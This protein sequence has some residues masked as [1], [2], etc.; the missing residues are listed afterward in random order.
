MAADVRDFG[1]G[2][3]G[4]G[5]RAIRLSSAELS[6]TVLTW[7]GALQDL[8][9]A[10]I[11]RSLT[12]GGTRMEAYEGPMGYFGTLVGPVANR[13]GG[14]R[15]LIDGR[16]CRFPA[17]E[18]P[19]LLHGGATGI[20]ARHWALDGADADSVRLRLVAEDGDD[21]FPGRR[22]ITAVYRV[23]GAALTLELTGTTDAP[24]LMNLAHHGYWNLDG[25][26][27]IAGHRLRVPADHY[28]PTD[29]A[30]LPTGEIRPVSGT[31]DLRAGRV[32]D[33]GEGFDTNFCIAAAAGPLAE[34]AELVGRSGVAMR[35]DSTEP[36]LQVY[37]GRFLNTA[38]FA[39]HTGRPYGAHEGLALE[40]Q[41]WPDAPNHP[42]FP[43]IGLAPGETYRQVTRWS[44]SAP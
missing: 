11:D 28:L 19:N 2:R 42:A 26:P 13:I 44:F 6:A 36:G 21:G 15:A 30:L 40:P 20:Q 31:H 23:E 25:T 43:P 37:D 9:L 38:P 14:A 8:R 10:G 18:G 3:D 29:A 24:T 5:V 34:V 16:E 39:G 17:N 27:T 22:E 35:I 1:H 4:R 32:L 7:G 41:L 12:L 33:L